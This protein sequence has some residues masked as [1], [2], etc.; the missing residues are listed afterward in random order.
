[1]YLHVPGYLARMGKVQWVYSVEGM[2]TGDMIGC[3]VVCR[4]E[5]ER[6]LGAW[7]EDSK[8]ACH[9][10]AAGVDVA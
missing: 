5:R 10:G 2:D 1:M 9:T 3:E 6:K 4:G 7:W 8:I